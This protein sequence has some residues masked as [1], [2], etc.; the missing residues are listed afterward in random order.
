[1]DQ[2]VYNAL[3]VWKVDFDLAHGTGANDAQRIRGIGHVDMLIQAAMV[4]FGEESEAAEV[5]VSEDY[6]ERLA[7]MN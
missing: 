1:M 7:D 2:G 3:L 5:R 6:A 4:T